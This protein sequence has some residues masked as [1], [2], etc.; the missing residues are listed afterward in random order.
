MKRYRPGNSFHQSLATIYRNQDGSMPTTAHLEVRRRGKIRIAALLLG[1]VILCILGAWAAYNIFTNQQGDN[2]NKNLT[3]ALMGAEQMASGDQITYTFNYHNTDTLTLRGVEVIFRYPDSFTFGSA[4]PAPDNDFNT[5][6]KLGDIPAGARGSIAVRGRI[7]GDIGSTQT[8]YA[9]VSYVP[10]NFSSA[11]K[12]QISFD[13]QIISSTLSL[14]VVVPEEVLAEKKITYIVTY[15][16]NS[17]T[18]LKDIKIT[19]EYPESFVFQESKPIPWKREDDARTLNNTWIVDQLAPGQEG[20]L[21]VVGG[22]L[23]DNDTRPESIPFAI[24]FIDSSS[25]ELVLQQKQVA[26][27]NVVTPGFDIALVVNGSSQDQ[28]VGFGQPLTYSINYKNRGKFDLDDATITLFVDSQVVDWK[29]LEDIHRGDVTKPG[30]ITWRKEHLSSLDLIK[31]GDEGTIDVILPVKAAADLPVGTITLQT[32]SKAEISFAAI[33]SLTATDTVLMTNEIANNI[34]TDIQL[35]V[36]GRYFDDDNIPVGSGPLPPVVGQTTT[37]RIFWS[38]DNSL[39]EVKD[40]VMTT[41]LP[42]TVRWSG[43]SLASVGTIQENAGVVTWRISTIPGGKS[44][45]DTNAWFDVEVTPTKDHVRKLLILTDQANLVAMDTV[46]NTPI[47]KTSKAITSNLDDDPIG[48]GKGLVI[49][50]TE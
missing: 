14:N 7:I 42:A 45:S 23:G 27:T 9:T 49:D 36:Q 48:G 25:D 15:K 24:G 31:P 11:F 47:T 46:T 20:R 34:N 5:V 13:G 35:T 3:I 38:I 2:S 4:E 10:E 50:I 41:T 39:N 22:F 19:A 21:E 40:V 1:I 43:K 16:N 44:S 32:K 30:Q 8:A 6:W 17:D 33:G 12:E 26:T 18:T 29:A 28:P 37:F